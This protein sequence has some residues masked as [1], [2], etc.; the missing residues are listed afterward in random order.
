MI[1]FFPHSYLRD[2]QIDTITSWP[3]DQVCNLEITNSLV[4]KQV[5]K[6]QAN[7]KK[8][9]VSWKT[10]LPLM[11]IKLRPQKAPKNAVIYLWGGVTLNGRF[12][13]DLDNPWSLTAYNLRAM[14]LYKWV[15][16]RI[17]LSKR[18]VEIRCMS[19]AC[20]LSLKELFGMDV[21]N[22]AKVHYPQIKQKVK[23]IEER[24]DGECKFLFVAT[25][26]EIKGGSAL[27]KAFER[28]YNK[29]GYCKLDLITHLPA[30]YNAF[31][32]ACEGIKVHEAK[33]TREQIHTQFMQNVDVLV[34]P[35]Y[36]E[37]FGMVAL[38]ALAHGLALITTDVY[39]LGEMVKD[40][41]NGDL[42]VPPISVWD[43]TM[44]AP[45]YYDLPNIKKRI[46]ATDTSYFELQL[47][48]AIERFVDD[49]AWRLHA[50]QAS[51]KLME[52]NFAC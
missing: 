40:G 49:T 25:Q 3:N 35:T 37:S 20:K 32:K 52:E 9:E 36:V 1:Y 47:E 45:A 46:R 15:I 48:Q 27:L 8:Q 29:K 22:K 14:K 17:L 44:P 12:I 24:K 39:A 26:F 2:R 38:E 34:L 10:R 50:R 18:C 21:Y 41:V 7:K 30:K 4:G 42:I 51:I 11:N 16:R 33:F 13:V 5:S 31:V 28:V 6:K 19:K 43:G 23:Y